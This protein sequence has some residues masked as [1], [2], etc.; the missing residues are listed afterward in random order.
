[1]AKTIWKPKASKNI[2]WR[3]SD[4]LSS[5]CISVDV[6]FAPVP[7]LLLPPQPPKCPTLPRH[8]CRHPAVTPTAAAIV[9]HSPRTILPAPPLLL[10]PRLLK[11][12]THP[13]YHCR[14][15]R[16]YSHRSCH[17]ATLTPDNTAGTTAVNPTA[18]ATLPHSP[19][20]SLQ[21]PPM[22]LLPLLPQYETHPGTVPD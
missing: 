16:C 22:L 12:H 19:Q 13:R 17:S 15:H 20:A 11:C 8:Y 21:A 14:H 3:R 18:A 4:L 2:F 7:P 10:P 1:M 9:P 5:K 6:S